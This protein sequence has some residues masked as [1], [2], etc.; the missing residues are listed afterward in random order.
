M[1][2]RW[3]MQE[4]HSGARGIDQLQLVF[5]ELPKLDR[6]REPQTLVEKW[7]YFFSEAP[8]LEVVPPPLAA[9]PPLVDAFEAARLA[10]FT[11]D[12]WDD[13][14]AQLI[15]IQDEIGVETGA[16]KRGHA[17]GLKEGRLE[18]IEMLCDVLQIPLDA[19]RRAE[20]AALDAAGLEALLQRIRARRAWE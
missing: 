3:R 9:E 10:S 1:L 17:E 16:L 4:Q 15:A 7:A 6:S 18:A 5:L 14:T 12:E 19:N 20:L 8:N 2:S 11:K 13:Y